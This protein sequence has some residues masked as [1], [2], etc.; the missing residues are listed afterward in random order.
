MKFLRLQID[1]N[2]WRRKYIKWWAVVLIFICVVQTV[3]HA[4]AQNGPC[5]VWE[6][7]RAEQQGNRLLMGGAAVGVLVGF[8]I[9][10]PFGAGIALGAMV[11]GAIGGGN[12]MAM[13]M[14]QC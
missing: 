14:S 1:D 13:T 3:P 2:D 6:N 10:G 11:A 7:A 8:L 4:V 12:D 5:G 9:G